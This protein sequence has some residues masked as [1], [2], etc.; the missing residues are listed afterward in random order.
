[1][2]VIDLLWDAGADIMVEDEDGHNLLHAACFESNVEVAEKLIRMGVEVNPTNT[3][4]EIT[5]LSVAVQEDC[6]DLVNL[7]LEHGAR[8]D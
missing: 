5:P 4:I 1:M 3:G 2:E 6:L 7:L 8:L